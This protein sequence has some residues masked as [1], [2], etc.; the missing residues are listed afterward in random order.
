MFRASLLIALIIS[1]SATAMEGY[2]QSPSLR[3][4]TITFTA[5]GDLW[6]YRLGSKQAKRLT[7]HP[8]L[9][10]NS[11][12]S[13][14]GEQ[15]AFVADY[16]GVAEAYLMPISGGVPK[17]LTYE[18]EGVFVHGWTADGLLLYSTSSRVGPPYNM[19]LKTVN[20]TML[21]V[22]PIP[23]ADAFDGAINADTGF[24]YF[25]QF[26]LQWSGDNASTYRGGMQGK[27]WRCASNTI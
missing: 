23:L 9:E 20:P 14:N 19:T 7:T 13:L 24:V 8:S 18:N 4:D 11:S 26:G 6:L 25:T 5:E 27:L 2:Y 3:G 1:S 15:I 12:I 16:E 10:T 17:R 22:E 21:E